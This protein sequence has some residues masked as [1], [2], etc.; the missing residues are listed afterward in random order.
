MNPVYVLEQRITNRSEVFQLKFAREA[1]ALLAEAGLAPRASHAGLL[2][3]ADGE[4]ALVHAAD[5]LRAR[6][7][8]CLQTERP[9]VLYVHE[10]VLMEPVMEAVVTVPYA[11]AAAIERNLLGRGA[12]VLEALVED[13]ISRIH[14]E[15]PMAKLLGYA[16]YL[17][18]A[19][20]GAGTC[21]TAFRRYAP[22]DPGGSAA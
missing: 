6:Y 19:T 2:L 17:R 21:R 1:E 9:R 18:N 12:L 14:A 22:V 3:L 5:V 13:G 8:D 7:G 10:P 4:A 16:D 11:G 20:R 15:L